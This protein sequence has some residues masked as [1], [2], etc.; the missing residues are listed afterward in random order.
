MLECLELKKTINV[1]CTS[2]ESLSHAWVRYLLILCVSLILSMA[3]S[4]CGCWH[5][6]KQASGELTPQGIPIEVSRMNDKGYLEALNQH[7]E[8][9]K[10]VA[11]ERNE[12]AEKLKLCA[13][14]VKAGLASDVSEE[15]FKAA[16]EKDAEWQSYH[17]HQDALDQRVQDD[18][19]EARETVRMRLIKEQADAAAYGK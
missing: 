8:S 6:K 17:E 15:D 2:C 16:L 4:G 19:K 9:Q 14:R 1:V 3:L 10:V 5:K 12:L 13:D 11:R 7:R 18:L